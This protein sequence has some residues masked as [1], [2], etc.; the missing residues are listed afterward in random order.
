MGAFSQSLCM[1]GWLPRFP[2]RGRPATA[3]IKRYFH[4]IA[5]AFRGGLCTP[6]SGAVRG[7]AGLG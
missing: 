3:A 1:D 2:D 6:P 4:S 7:Y 5:W